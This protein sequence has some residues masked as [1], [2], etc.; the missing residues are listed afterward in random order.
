MHS[1]FQQE[2]ILI[3]KDKIELFRPFS[4]KENEIK[5]LM[6]RFNE[7]EDTNFILETLSDS[8]SK[9]TYID[10]YNLL[11]LLCKLIEDKKILNE[12]TLSLINLRMEWILD[13]HS[14]DNVRIDAL[15]I[16]YATRLKNI[17]YFTKWFNRAIQ[18]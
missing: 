14:S 10:T 17:D 5:I 13:N 6:L 15:E 18:E 3:Q 8:I 4:D 12:D 2:F 7:I 9:E 1:K 16:I 11:N